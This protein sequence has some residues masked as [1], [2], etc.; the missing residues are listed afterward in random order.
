MRRTQPIGSESVHPHL[1]PAGDTRLRFRPLDRSDR[2][3]FAALFR[4]LSPESRHRRYL[5]PMQK[6]TAAQLAYLTDIDHLK[7][8]AIAAVDERDGSIVGVARYVAERGQARI[9]EVAVEV[10]DEFQNRGIGTALTEATVARARANRFDLLTAT[11]LWDN[12]PARS[13]LRRLGFRTRASH[14]REIDLELVLNR[15]SH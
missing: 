14:G 4:Q 11:T 12:W 6:L 15:S 3:E 5:S 9:A 13:L 2:A 10:L 8:E 7:H 1:Y